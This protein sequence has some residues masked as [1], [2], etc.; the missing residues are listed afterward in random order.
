MK[1]IGQLDGEYISSDMFVA[2]PQSS[3]PNP[4][5]DPTSIALTTCASHLMNNKLS[6]QDGED[7]LD[8]SDDDFIQLSLADSLKKLS[9]KK[10]AID[11]MHHRF[12]GKSSGVMLIQTAIDLKNQYTGNGIEDRKEIL[13]H[14][15]AEFWKMRPVSDCYQS[16]QQ[17]VLTFHQVG[18]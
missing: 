3:G 9:L 5:S 7:N 13:G 4:Y 11:P 17:C 12:F 14:G 18:N 8:Q 2:P 10:L 6:P 16:T 15:R 1:E